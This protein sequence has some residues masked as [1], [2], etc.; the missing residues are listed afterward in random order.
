MVFLS[1]D[2]ENIT[3]IEQKDVTLDMEKNLLI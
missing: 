1:K 3:G 2:G